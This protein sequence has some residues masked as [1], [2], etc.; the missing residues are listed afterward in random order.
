MAAK[1]EH[2]QMSER[3]V[4]L[5]TKQDVLFNEL[6]DYKQSLTQCTEA[7]N[8]LTETVLEHNI[9]LQEASKK[10]DKFGTIFGGIVTGVVTAILIS[11]FALI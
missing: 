4:Q 10:G 1:E 5:E 2:C 3:I 6:D 7:I 8:K 11:I 9:L